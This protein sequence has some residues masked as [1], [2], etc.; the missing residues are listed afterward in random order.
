MYAVCQNNESPHSLDN[1]NPNLNPIPSRV[2]SR[3][4]CVCT[5][6]VRASDFFA[7]LTLTG[8]GRWIF[9]GVLNGWPALTGLEVRSITGI[10]R[11]PLGAPTIQRFWNAPDHPTG[12]LELRVPKA[13]RADP[14]C[15]PAKA[16]LTGVR[17]TLR[18]A[19]WSAE[20]YAAR[21]PGFAFWY[22]GVPSSGPPRLFFGERMVAAAEANAAEGA[23][24][25]EAAPVVERVHMFAHRYA[26]DCAHETAKARLTWHAGILLE[27]SH[28][29]HVTVV[30]LA[31]LHGLGGYGGKSNWVEDKDAR[32]PA[33]YDAM[34]AALKA[35]W[36]VELSELRVIDVPQRSAA[37]FL[38]FMHAHSGRTKRFLEPVIAHSAAVRVTFR[39][40]AAIL[41]YLLNYGRHEPRYSEKWRN[42][43]TFAADFFGF[44]SGR[45]C[46]GADGVLPYAT[47]NRVFYTPHAEWFVC[48]PPPPAAHPAAANRKCTTSS[49]CSSSYSTAV[50]PMPEATG[51]PD[52]ANAAVGAAL[53][54]AC[55]RR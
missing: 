24:R 6:Q 36:R 31:W 44:L 12:A 41:R 45:P 53:A 49:S 21:N 35:P 39:S 42:C 9:T 10:V 18:A 37:E 38:A 43:Q 28:G 19:P 55:A 3:V 51:A 5:P 26:S 27:W 25:G 20:G 30:E 7:S 54:Q 14:P 34:P 22:A 2:T 15:W 1:P 48:D 17:V 16:K 8:D 23:L 29:R 33:L 4:Y 52:A 47:I 32:R 13:N 40:Q 50:R 46:G 11:T